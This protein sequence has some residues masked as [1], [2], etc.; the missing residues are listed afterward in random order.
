MTFAASR[1]FT[2]P[3]DGTPVDLAQLASCSSGVL[4]VEFSG[5]VSSSIDGSELDAVSRWEGPTQQPWVGPFVLL[6]AGSRMVES[7][8]VGRRYVFEVPCTDAMPVRFDVMPLAIRRLVSRTEADRTLQG[9]IEA[10]ITVPGFPTL[11]ADRASMTVH[12]AMAG[13]VAAGLVMLRRRRNREELR[14]QRRAKTLASG[15]RR[16]VRSLGPAFGGVEASS[17]KLLEVIRA[18]R[19]EVEQTRHTLHQIAMLGES[20]ASERREWLVSRETSALERMRL[21]VKRLEQLVAQLA[22]HALES[23]TPADVD[24]LLRCL[25]DEVARAVRAERELRDAAPSS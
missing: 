6:P 16:H 20:A 4:R 25:E 17:F 9:A 14:L 23:R 24:T 19:E 1:R 18:L 7:D 13:T 22:S 15:I 2:L 12:W 10:E 8:P 3:L 11:R 5:T 21:L